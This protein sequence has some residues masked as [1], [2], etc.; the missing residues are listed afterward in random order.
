M[1]KIG[2]TIESGKLVDVFECDTC[3]MRSKDKELIKKC[4]IKH[5]HEEEAKVGLL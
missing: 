2:K 3:G 4:E 5:H 1:R